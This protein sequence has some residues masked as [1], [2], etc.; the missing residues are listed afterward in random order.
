M[1]MKSLFCS[2]A[3]LLAATTGVKAVNIVTSTSTTTNTVGTPVT[4]TNW[5]TGWSG[6]YDGLDYVGVVNGTSTGG[7]SG[8]GW[9]S[10]GVYLGDGW[11]LTAAHVGSGEFTLAGNT[12]SIIAGSTTTVQSGVDLLMFRIDTSSGTLPTSGLTLSGSSPTSGSQVV[13]VGC[14]GQVESWGVNTV[15]QFQTGTRF[16]QPVYSTTYS[17]SVTGTGSVTGLTTTYSSTDFGT[18][19][20]DTNPAEVVVGDSGGAAYIYNSSTGTWE[21]AGILEAK[22]DASGDS[23]MVNLATYK[24]KI[25]NIMVSAVPEP[26]T[27]ALMAMG[28]L[29]VV[30]AARRNRRLR[31]DRLT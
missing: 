10:S 26:Q 22:D 29:V 27:N 30:L 7:G 1:D 19:H 20:S 4:A 15:S 25:T 2:V 16:G 24:T 6:G 5:S 8:D 21:L 17:V 14:A 23:F 18:A 12:Y 13:M 3:F 31:S 28:A 9:Y 11:V